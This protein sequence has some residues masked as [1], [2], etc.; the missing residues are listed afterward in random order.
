MLRQIFLDTTKFGRGRKKL[1]GPAPECPAPWLAR[2][3]VLRTKV[4]F[5]VTKWSILHCR[6][7]SLVRFDWRNYVTLH[8]RSPLRSPLQSLL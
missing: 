2:R 7:N 6:F 4:A 5:T 1:G 8:L 3:L